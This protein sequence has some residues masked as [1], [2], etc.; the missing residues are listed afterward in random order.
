MSIHKNYKKQED[1]DGF[2]NHDFGNLTG[3]TRVS[4]LTVALPIELSRV[5]VLYKDISCLNSNSDIPI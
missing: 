1:Q 2:G 4:R 3:L 5:P